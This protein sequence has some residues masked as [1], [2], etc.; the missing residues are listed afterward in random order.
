VKVTYTPNG[1]VTS[2][3]PVGKHAPAQSACV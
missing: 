2:A 1:H 3:A